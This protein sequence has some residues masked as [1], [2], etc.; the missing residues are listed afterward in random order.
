MDVLAIT[1]GVLALAAIVGQKAVVWRVMR[2][3]PVALAAQHEFLLSAIDHL[4][5]DTVLEAAQADAFREEARQEEQVW[6]ANETALSATV[7]EQVVMGHPR[8]AAVGR[9]AM[10]VAGLD[11]DDAQAV[12]NWNDRLG[13]GH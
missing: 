7:D 5:A 2:G 8:E 10:I 6:E 11:P 3:A 13:A 9:A 12:I 1:I 4:K